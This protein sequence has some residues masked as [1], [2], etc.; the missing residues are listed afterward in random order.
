MIKKG[1]IKLYVDISEF[2][3]VELV[4][5]QDVFD[6]DNEDMRIRRLKNVPFIAYLEGSYFGDQDVIV[7]KA[8]YFERDASAI[9]SM[10][11]HFFVLSRDVLM[12]LKPVFKAELRE[13]EDLS[14]RRRNKH[15]KLIQNLKKK[16]I[17]LQNQH[18]K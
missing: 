7:P 10:E 17:K 4:G 11:S 3:N 9:A 5:A 15:Y 2:L 16:V 6:D 8:T 12:Q 18:P 1:K 13:I 14:S